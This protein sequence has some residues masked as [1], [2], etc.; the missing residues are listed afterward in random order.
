MTDSNWT[1]TIKQISRFII[2]LILGPPLFEALS[3]AWRFPWKEINDTLLNLDMSSVLT[4]G[5]LTVPPGLPAALESLARA[6]LKEQPTDLPNFAAA[7]FRVLL[8]ER[9]GLNSQERGKLN[10]L[11]IRIGQRS[12]HRFNIL[13]QWNNPAQVHRPLARVTTSRWGKQLS[14]LRLKPN[15]QNEGKTVT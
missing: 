9:T 1:Y 6:V 8:A 13:Q 4:S 10:F 15:C 7:H 2:V 12:V 14:W 3:A 5:Q 11:Q